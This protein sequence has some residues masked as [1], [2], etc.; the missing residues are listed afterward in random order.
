[1]FVFDSNRKYKGDWSNVGEFNY[2]LVSLTIEELKAVLKTIN[3]Y[4]ILPDNRL[5]NV[6]TNCLTLYQYAL[7]SIEPAYIFLNFWQI[8]ELVS[9]KDQLGNTENKVKTRITA[10][11]KNNSTI[12]DILEVLFCKRNHLV[13]EGRLEDFSLSDVNE[14][15][16]I[17]EGAMSFLFSQVEK[18]ENYPNLETFYENIKEKD[19]VKEK[20]RILN[21]INKLP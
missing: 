10:I 12:S 13:H 18:L 3:D 15:R 4:N 21:Y 5:K 7:D 1:M 14:I 11:Y 8:L 2:R 6:L 19:K 20:L 17:T 16:G 9:L